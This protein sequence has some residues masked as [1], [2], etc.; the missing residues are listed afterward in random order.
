VSAV[1]LGDAAAPLD[2]RATDFNS[3]SGG[4]WGLDRKRILPEREG[5]IKQRSFY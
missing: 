5:Y 2:L 3:G 1:S 4:N